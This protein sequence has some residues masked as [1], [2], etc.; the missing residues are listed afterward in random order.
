MARKRKP[1]LMTFLK[2]AKG[3]GR[4][5]LGAKTV[6]IFQQTLQILKQPKHFPPVDTF[7]S[8]NATSKPALLGKGL[9]ISGPTHPNDLFV[10]EQARFQLLKAGKPAANVELAILKGDTRYRNERGEVKVT[11]DKNGF[12][13][14]TWQ[15]PG[16]YLIE[17]S[18]SEESSEKGIDNVR[19]SLFT[20][21]DVAPE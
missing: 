5:V 21:L 16:L 9:E 3:E 19:Y 12:F 13:S 14:T 10:G 1:R 15:H 7:V 4:R 8:R 2:D 11:T 20:T 18:V 6:K 17:A